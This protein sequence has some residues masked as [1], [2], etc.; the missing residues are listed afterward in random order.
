MNI[1]SEEDNLR[2]LSHNTVYQLYS[3]R[4]GLMW[5][6]TYKKGIS[7][8]S[9]S[10]FKFTMYELGDITCVEQAGEGLLWLGTNDDGLL[11]WDVSTAQ[12]RGRID[13]DYPVVSL[14]KDRQGR[15]WIG[16]FNGGLYCRDGEHLSR[17]TTAD[18]LLN[19]SI[20]PC[21]RRMVVF[22]L[23]IW[24]EVSNI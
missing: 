19:N 12:I 10:L 7:Y 5:V 6:G 9:E 11:L 1:V 16:T 3:D 8:Y 21:R 24:R 4:N 17:Y 22:G 2:S 13:F 14:L 18:G 23:V 15:L 20:G